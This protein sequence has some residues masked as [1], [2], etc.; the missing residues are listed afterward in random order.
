ME[1]FKKKYWNKSTKLNGEMILDEILQYSPVVSY[2]INLASGSYEYLSSS[3]ENILGWPRIQFLKQGREFT[4]EIM[5]PEDFN[6]VEAII[7]SANTL[8]EVPSNTNEIEFRL[9][10]KN[11]SYRWFLDRLT[12]INDDTTNTR[13]IVGSIVDITERKSTEFALLE[14]EE[15]FRNFLDQAPFAIQIYDLDGILQVTNKMDFVLWGIDPKTVIGKYNLFHDDQIKTIG[16]FPDIQEAYLG[17]YPAPKEIYYDPKQSGLLTSR[18][19]LWLLTSIFPLKNDQNQIS[20]IVVIHQDISEQKQNLLKL[21]ESEEKY[22][23]LFQ[24]SRDALILQTNSG[25]II[26]ANQSAQ[27][28]FGYSREEFMQLVT[29]DLHPTDR[30]QF[31]GHITQEFL[32]GSKASYEILMQ[33]KDG[34]H[35]ESSVKAM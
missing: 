23:Q 14:S 32:K 6:R 22:N 8:Q 26:E 21:Q 27:D 12:V 20:S 25:K 35:F 24:K 11:G 31:Q 19:P 3:V 18:K 9:R 34:T 17:N 1:W 16:I 5:H 7:S 29:N 2:K 4:K 13:Y 15:K 10:H 28:L 33:R 30:K